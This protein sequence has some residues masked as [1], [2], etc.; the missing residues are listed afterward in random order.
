M[1]TIAQLPKGIW[2]EAPKRRFRVRRY[3]NKVTHLKGYYRT[4]N[5]AQA[6]L[7]EL[8]EELALIPKEKRKLPT[9]TLLLRRSR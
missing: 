3:H 8:N 1:S 6:A 4:F 7:N 2:Y 5:A 9:W